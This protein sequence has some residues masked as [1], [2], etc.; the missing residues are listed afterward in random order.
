LRYVNSVKDLG[1]LLLSVGKP[2]RYTGGE[3]GIT[4][5]KDAA[6]KTVIA[7]PDLYEIGMGNQA[8][9][10]I[11]NR[12][13]E[14]PD[15]LCDRAFAPAPDFEKL[16]KE[17]SIPLYGLDTG[18][19]LCNFDIVMFTIGYELGLNGVLTMLNAG[20][21]PLRSN[22][23]GNNMPVVI[24]GGPVVSNPIPFSPF[25][26][27]FWIGEA[28]AGFFDLVQELSETKKAG[29]GSAPAREQ[30]LKKISAHPSVFVKGKEKTVRAIHTGFSADIKSSIYP[31]PSMK[32][33]QNHGTVEIMRGCPNGC[34]F[35]HAG[36]WYRPMRQKNRDLIIQQA[37]DIVNKSGWQQISLSSL[38]SGDYCGVSELV[39]TLNGK[40]ADK[41]VSFQMPSL[42]VSGFS[43]DL[44]EK[45]SITRKSGL[46]FAVETPL[47]MLQMAINKE[48]T[49]D[50]IVSILEEAKKRGWKSAKFYFMIGLPVGCNQ[51]NEYFEEKE[52]V[53]FIFD[54]S[55]R[56]RLKFNIN[57]GVFIP[58][59]HTPYQHAAQIGAEEAK[60]KL[61]FIRSK[62]KP[63]GHKVST[64]NLLISKIEG[65]LSRGDERAGYL[66][67]KVFMEGSRLDA[68]DE[69]IN[70]EK[71]EEHLN[72]NID[73]LNETLSGSI[74]PPWSCIESGI[75]M[76]YLQNELEK[77]NNCQRTSPC[78]EMCKKCSL[79]N[80]SV[81][82]TKNMDFTDIAISTTDNTDKNIVNHN[83]TSVNK[84]IFR[85]IFSFSKKGSAVFHGHLSLIDIFSMS[86]RRA[87]ISVMFT[88]GFNPL[89]KME[90]AAPLTT[91]ISS[92]CEIALVDFYEEPNTKVFIE[93]LNK[94]LPEG[95]F[96]KEAEYFYIPHGTK[97]YSLSSLLWGAA[98]SAGD[99]IDYIEF[100]QEKNYRQSRL[101][102]DCKSLF[103]LNRADVLAK[104]II[105]NTKEWASY[106]DVYKHLYIGRQNIHYA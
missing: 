93:N 99:K 23:R 10:I 3:Y 94:S 71:W 78:E 85:L 54:V 91:G 82:I 68:W 43:L 66:C 84:G 72:E 101:E 77:S 97:H 96:V 33:I 74:P 55:R 45:I 17:N 81:K 65:L 20:S 6:L 106:F 105:N 59:P 24:A 32:I 64:S 104:N 42:K 34:R 28:E 16:L 37:E 25:I 35:C 9:R 80:N 7:F 75:N 26:D 19:A 14:L 1:G 50:S 18:L 21:I 73:L 30:L 56:T 4:A 58:K 12:I 31:I 69:Y 52:I 13:N 22:A 92:D 76:E 2:G 11:Y 67:E 41:H 83:K 27:A 103:E 8:L 38:S 90:F 88:Q 53:D 15:V 95:I 61:Y 44:L 79:C 48:V 36:F 39:E 63:L 5:K 89:A 60:E 62:L 100:T 29:Q 57:V 51:E 47:D 87:G 86:F 98:Y 70:K 46:T 40:F 102:K 49:R